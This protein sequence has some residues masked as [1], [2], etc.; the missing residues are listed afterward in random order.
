MISNLLI[1]GLEGLTL[2]DHEKDFLEKYQPA[3]VILFSRNYESPAQLVELIA[4]I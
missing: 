4:S 1:V 3:G 2:T